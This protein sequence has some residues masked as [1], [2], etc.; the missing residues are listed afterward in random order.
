MQEDW[1]VDDAKGKHDAHCKACEAGKYQESLRQESSDNCIDCPSGTFS[2][3]SS[4]SREADCGHCPAGYY[5]D[6]SGLQIAKEGQGTCMSREPGEI[7]NTLCTS[8][9][10]CQDYLIFAPTMAPKKCA[11]KTMLTSGE[12]FCTPCIVGLYQDLTGKTSA[13]DCKKCPPGKYNDEIA[14]VSSL[15]VKLAHCALC[16]TGF[17]SDL[18]ERTSIDD[19][20][21]CPIGTFGEREGASHSRE[22][23]ECPA[24][25]YQ[26]ELKTTSMSL[27]KRSSCKK[28]T[29]GRYRSEAKGT[30]LDTCKLCPKGKYQDLVAQ[31]T[32]SSC[33]SCSQGTYLD[34]TGGQKRGD[35]IGCRFFFCFFF[36]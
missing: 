7:T 36:N 12:R 32:P 5:G 3:A 9:N 35:C 24:G 22:C 21:P 1:V 11:S 17:W 16:P 13:A 2:P 15:I 25:Y 34:V 8:N 20:Q 23:E 19:C 31:T 26:D 29:N 4:V 30:S 10:D 14:A 28:C 6:Q 27:L 33:K 18:Q